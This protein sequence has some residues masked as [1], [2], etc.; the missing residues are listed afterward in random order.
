MLGKDFKVDGCRAVQP[1]I[2]ALDLKREYLMGSFMYAKLR[3]KYEG[4]DENLKN[5]LQDYQRAL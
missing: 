4:F 1:D 2:E 3:L 5:E